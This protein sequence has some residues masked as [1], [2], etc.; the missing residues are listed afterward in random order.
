M[1]PSLCNIIA[2]SA[3]FLVDDQKVISNLLERSPNEIVWL[4]LSRRTIYFDVNI[5][6]QPSSSIYKCI[7]SDYEF[8]TDLKTIVYTNSMKSAQGAI[9]DATEAILD[10]SPNVGEPIA[11]NAG[12][13][14]LRA[15]LTEI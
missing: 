11:L 10:A 14:R 12:I 6:G 4:E 13:Q 1:M 15:A 2:M 5:C 3:T 8:K 7:A 9:T